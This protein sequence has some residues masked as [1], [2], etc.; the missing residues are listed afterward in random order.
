VFEE[1]R[2]PSTGSRWDMRWESSR[3]KR[4]FSGKISVAVTE[5]CFDAGA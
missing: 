1:H 2:L 5:K 4:R 3:K